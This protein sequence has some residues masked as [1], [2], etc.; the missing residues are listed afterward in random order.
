MTFKE[1]K[2]MKIKYH[3][4]HDDYNML[5]ITIIGHYQ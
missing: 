5:D 3:N 4:Y 2:S 1:M